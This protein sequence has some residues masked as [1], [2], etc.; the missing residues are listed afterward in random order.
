MVKG[1]L[2][3]VAKTLKRWKVVMVELPNKNNSGEPVNG[4]K[5]VEFGPAQPPLVFLLNFTIVVIYLQKQ[6]KLKLK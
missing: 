4:I 3:G 5:W 2:T 1:G 6:A